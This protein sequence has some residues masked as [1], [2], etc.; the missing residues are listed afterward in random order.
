MKILKSSASLIILILFSV[1][2]YSCDDPVSPDPIDYYIS[3][4]PVITGFIKTSED[5]PDPLGVWGESNGKS[6]LPGG[7]YMGVPYPNPTDRFTR[8]TYGIPEE[9]YVSIWIVRGRLPG[10]SESGYKLFTNGYFAK[11]NIKLSAKIFEGNRV[12]GY[13]RQ[14][15][16]LNNLSTG[17]VPDGLYRVYIEINGEFMWQDIMKYYLSGTEDGIF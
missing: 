2:Y 10:E 1:L 5:S 15:I 16:D 17:V 4:P 13:Y 9:S 8:I 11:N 3:N 6:E 12:P 14:D 7:Y